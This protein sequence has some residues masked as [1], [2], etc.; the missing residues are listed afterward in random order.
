MGRKPRSDSKLDSLPDHHHAALVKMLLENTKYEEVLTWLA[1]E[2]AVSSSLSALS[3][4]YQRHCTPVLKER[5]QLAVMRAEEFSKAAEESPVDWD[6]AAMERLNQIFFEL[7]LQPDVDA[8]T[9]K[10]LGDMILKDKALSMDSR[11]LAMLEAKERKL[12]EAKKALKE[13]Q[14]TGGLSA[15]TMAEIERTLGML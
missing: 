12:E 11:K 9:A 6:A 10:R 1:V 4:F 7:L 13:R 3:G 2:C 8:A 14:N 5:R 15:E